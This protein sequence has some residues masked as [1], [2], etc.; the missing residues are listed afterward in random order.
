MKPKLITF[1][2]LT[3][4]ESLPVSE[5]E[6]LDEAFIFLNENKLIENDLKIEYD[7]CEN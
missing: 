2:F 3:D 1:G 7:F 4:I 5:L 6:R